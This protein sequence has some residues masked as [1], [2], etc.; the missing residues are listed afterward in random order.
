MFS[1][2]KIDSLLASIDP[3]LLELPPQIEVSEEDSGDEGAEAD[4]GPIDAELLKELDELNATRAAPEPK[5]QVAPEDPDLVQ[6]LAALVGEKV[7]VTESVS[8]PQFSE[9]QLRQ[10]QFELKAAA[11]AFK[12]SAD[13]ATAKKLMAEAKLLDDAIM[14]VGEGLPLE[15]GFTLPKIPIPPTENIPAVAKLERPQSPIKEKPKKLPAQPTLADQFDSLVIKLEAQVDLAGQLARQFFRL[16]DRSNALRFQR[17]RKGFQAQMEQ[18]ESCRLQL[19]PA[20]PQTRTEV[21]TFSLP[22]EELDVAPNV[23]EVWFGRAWGLTHP[24]LGIKQPDS[25]VQCTLGFN[26][27]MGSSPVA[28]KTA[29]PSYDYTARLGVD[30]SRAWQ[31]HAERKSLTIEVLHYR[32]FLFQAWSLGRASIP[33]APLLRSPSLEQIVELTHP[34]SRRPTG[35]RIE[36]RIKMRRP[37]L[38]Q[39]AQQTQQEWIVVLPP[40]ETSQAQPAPE[41]A[42]E[43]KSN[44]TPTI[45]SPVIESSIK[46]KNA[47]PHP[48]PPENSNLPTESNQDEEK[49]SALAEFFNT[50]RIVAK[51]VIEMEIERLSSSSELAPL[52][53]GWDATEKRAEL[54]L[55]LNMLE[56]QAQLGQLDPSIYLGQLFASLSAHKTLAIRLKKLQL[57]A[58]A[59]QVMVHIKA[60]QTEVDELISMGITAP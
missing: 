32:G 24:Q 1:S 37:I 36:V 55:K 53:A 26:N 7:A 31:R 35:A 20:M 4:D 25:Y 33:L 21:V 39:P 38:P 3:S 17:Y 46:E 22:Q 52:P 51:T 18:V 8:L 48:T 9:Q 23:V 12:K 47:P 29:D 13:L 15:P 27:A 40:S 50:G 57:L 14:L 5:V 28:H 30:G 11:L 45:V 34:T 16:G 43:D 49:E 41:A 60:I 6:E 2:D 56:V 19:H 58:H 10:R 59:R 54:E 44:T 42:L